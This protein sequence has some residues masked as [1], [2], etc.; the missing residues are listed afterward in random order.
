MG[1]DDRDKTIG[2]QIAEGISEGLR[3][4]APPR[5]VKPG[6]S[7]FDPKTPFR[8]H[9]GPRL[10]GTVYENG[11]ACDEDR[12]T[13]TEIGLCNRITRSGRYLNRIVDVR[14]SDDAGARVVLLS[15]LDKSPDQRMMNK[16]HFR[17]LTELLTNVVAEQDKLVLA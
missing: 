11:V 3:E 10:K 12:L 16:D 17:N 2:R 13:D 6:S 8:S 14:V 4:I 9:K 15:F 7:A 1:N 5:R